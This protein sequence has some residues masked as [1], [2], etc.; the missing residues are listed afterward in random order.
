MSSWDK[1]IVGV[2]GGSFA[3]P[4]LGHFQFGLDLG[5]SRY[6]DRLEVTTVFDHTEKIFDFISPEHRLFMTQLMV[7]RLQLFSAAEFWDTKIQLSTREFDRGGKSRTLL[8]LQEIEEEGNIP[9]FVVG[10]DVAN[11]I[12]DWPDGSRILSRY[13]I[14]AWDRSGADYSSHHPRII[15]ANKTLIEAESSHT[16]RQKIARGEDVSNSLLP[17]VMQYIGV[18]GLFGFVNNR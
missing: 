5:R 7:S 15:R 3:P 12:K 16:I 14:V 2:W 17:E 1:E 11:R 18:H 13:D 6:F 10:M 9:I 8:T 4:H